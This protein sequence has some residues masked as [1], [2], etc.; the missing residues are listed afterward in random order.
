MKSKELIPSPQDDVNFNLIKEVADLLTSVGLHKEVLSSYYTNH[1]IVDAQAFPAEGQR[2]LLNRYWNQQLLKC[3]ANTISER[4]C[5]IPNG[6]IK[7]WLRLFQGKIL[8]VCLEYKL[9]VEL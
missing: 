1:W 8:P 3:E 6:T 2:L 4:C 7:D 5:L 9:P